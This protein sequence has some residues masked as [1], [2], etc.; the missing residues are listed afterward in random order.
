MKILC[1]DVGN[2]SIHYGIVD[3][4]TVMAS[5]HFSTIQLRSDS[6]GAFADLI[7]ALSMEADGISLCSV[8]PEINEIL[9]DSLPSTTLP[10]FH[11]THLNCYDLKLAYPKP[12][13][14]GQDRLANAIAA[15]EYYGVP[16]IILDMGTAVTLDIVSKSGYE[17]GII[18]PGL[19][20]MTNYLHE[21]T[22]LLPKLREEDLLQVEG[23]IGKSTVHAMQLGVAIGFSGMLDALLSRVFK[24]LKSRDGVNPIVLTTGGSVANL[25]KDWAQ[26]SHFVEDITLIG[27]ATAF[28]RSMQNTD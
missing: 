15:Q 27:L 1:I 11:L 18:A 3:K 26:K 8:V 5:G 14:I 19:A 9:I 13:E 28:R 21:Q 16:S 24:E 2:T 12:E 7:E 17:G 10:I 4:Q 6:S 23:A 25:I 20:V 22:A